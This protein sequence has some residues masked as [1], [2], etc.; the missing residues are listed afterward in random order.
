MTKEDLAYW[1]QKDSFLLS[2]D[3]VKDFYRS[4]FAKEFRK[5]YNPLIIYIIRSIPVRKPN[6]EDLLG[7]F[8]P[9]FI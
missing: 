2:Y 6:K 3:F 1:I 7:Q 8:K 5:V 4:A 9:E